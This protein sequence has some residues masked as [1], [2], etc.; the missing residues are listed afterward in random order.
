M[1]ASLSPGASEQFVTKFLDKDLAKLKQAKQ[2]ALELVDNLNLR[3]TETPKS[4]GWPCA[5]QQVPNLIRCV[6]F[7]TIL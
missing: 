7:G 5:R 6:K 1:L 4:A 2:A 3:P